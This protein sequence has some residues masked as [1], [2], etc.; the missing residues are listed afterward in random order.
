LK[1]TQ[2]VRQICM[3]VVEIAVNDAHRP[4]PVRETQARRR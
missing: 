1:T 2:V 3:K 4:P